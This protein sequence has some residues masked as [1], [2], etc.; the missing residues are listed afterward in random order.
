MV[1]AKINNW[2]KTENEGQV[3]VVFFFFFLIKKKNKTRNS[4]V[5]TADSVL[6]I[7]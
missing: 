5:S 6:V 1:P 3:C 4:V 2:Y 7:L